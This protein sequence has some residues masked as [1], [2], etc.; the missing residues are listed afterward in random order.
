[1]PAQRRRAAPRSFC[2]LLAALLPEA[3]AWPQ[4]APSEDVPDILLAAFI[5]TRPQV[6]R[7]ARVVV[8]PYRLSP[9]DT[10]PRLW[11][12]RDLRP[13]LA[14][15]SVRPGD[16][17]PKGRTLDGR[18]RQWRP[19]SGEVGVMFSVPEFRGDT[20]RLIV[21]LEG[22]TRSIDRLVL[23]RSRGKWVVVRRENI[24]VS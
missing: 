14:D 6:D 4:A 23:V 5:D 1:M 8:G 16:P 2:L 15:T 11:A 13:I 22:E 21:V 3:C 7:G 24:L 18:Q 17:T 19:P 9:T 20:A 12:E 10:V